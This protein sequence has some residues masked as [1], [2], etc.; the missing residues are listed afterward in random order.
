VLIPISRW[1]AA[2]AP[3]ISKQIEAARV[4][5]DD[6][7]FTVGYPPDRTSFA[8]IDPDR[9]TAELI[10]RLEAE[11]YAPI[12]FI[13]QLRQGTFQPDGLERLITLL[14]SIAPSQERTIDRK[15]VSLLW[16]LARF[17]RAAIPFRTIGRDAVAQLEQG[18]ATIE[19]LVPRIISGTL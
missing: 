1:S 5:I 2:L 18:A 12:G 4:Q 19:S 9:E 13:V 3:S 14:T 6:Q 7:R 11:I 17:M 16:D 15:L 8:R 10:R